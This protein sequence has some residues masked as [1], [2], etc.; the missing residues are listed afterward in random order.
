MDLNLVLKICWTIIVV[1]LTLIVIG[2]FIETIIKKIQ[3]PKKKK[4]MIKA[5]DNFTDEFIKWCEENKKEETPKAKA[6]NR[7]T[8]RKT[9]KKKE[10]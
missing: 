2:A 3:E 10:D 9:T 6:T 5:I 7:T 4:A 1:I 8:T